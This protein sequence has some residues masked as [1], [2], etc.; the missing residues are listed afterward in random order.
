MK[1]KKIIDS[2]ETLIHAT[3]IMTKAI[4]PSGFRLRD[5]EFC[6]NLINNW[7]YGLNSSQSPSIQLVQVSRMIEYYIDQRFMVR[8]KNKNP[9]QY[10]ISHPGIIYFFEQMVDSDKIKPPDQVIFIHYLLTTY[11]AFF[12][13]FLLND[14]LFQSTFQINSI[15]SYLNPSTIVKNQIALLEGKKNALLERIEE[16]NGLL[17]LINDERAKGSDNGQIVE[18][19]DHRFS[20]QMAYQKPFKNFLREIPSALLEF[21]MRVGFKNRRDLLFK[22]NINYYTSIIDLYL[23][24]LS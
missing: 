5:I 13:S 17:K 12:K 21:E 15:N 19:I 4:K 9:P 1:R 14:D 7:I 23:S 6:F 24:L 22:Q 11:S 16:N 10:K 3:F 20:Y 18:K 8:V 2:Y